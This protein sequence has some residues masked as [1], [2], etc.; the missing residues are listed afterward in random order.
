MACS[1]VLGPLRGP[2]LVALDGAGLVCKFVVGGRPVALGHVDEVEVVRTAL[3]GLGVEAER[4][5]VAA[6][7]AC[8][9][10]S[11]SFHACNVTDLQGAKRLVS[12]LIKID[13]SRWDQMCENYNKEIADILVMSPRTVNKHLEQI[14]NKLMVDKRTSAA[15]MAVR[16]LWRDS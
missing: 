4:H 5:L 11:D 12:S 2:E 8:L 9:F 15:T 10:Q 16:V 14:F 7:C 1:G 13:R 6:L 3:A